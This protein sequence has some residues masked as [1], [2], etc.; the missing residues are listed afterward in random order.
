M[1][2]TIAPLLAV[3]PHLRPFLSRCLALPTPELERVMAALERL[4]AG[5]R[6]DEAR[7]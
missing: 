7:G 6:G 2:T 3:P 5:E 1:N 4:T